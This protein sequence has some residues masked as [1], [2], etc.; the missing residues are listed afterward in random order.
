MDLKE[1]E[2]KAVLNQ[3][4]TLI[5]ETPDH[6]QNV[7]VFKRFITRLLKTQTYIVTLPIE[8]VMTIMKQKKPLVFAALRRD[9]SSII[10]IEIV[11][12]I[13]MEYQQAYRRLSDLKSKLGIIQKL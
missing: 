11:T 5:L 7:P 2:L 3:F 13:N 4:D 12:H 10:T 6:R 8:E 9:Y 1:P